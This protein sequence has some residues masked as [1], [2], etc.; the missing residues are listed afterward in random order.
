[1][2]V[3]LPVVIGGTVAIDNIRLPSAEY[4]DL[5]G[6]SATFATL[7]ASQFSDEVYLA[8][9]VGKDFPQMHLEMFARRNIRLDSLERS[10][11]STA[12]M[13]AQENLAT[14]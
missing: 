7:A 2:T 11:G 9:I 1:M 4:R 12:G 5:L 8:G 14:H 6:G 10:E 3:A 13:K